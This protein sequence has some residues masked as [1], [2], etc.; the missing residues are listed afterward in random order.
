ML[1]AH[2]ML[3]VLVLTTVP[4]LVALP[5]SSTL[6][7]NV[8]HVQAADLENRLDGVHLTIVTTEDPPFI[9]VRGPAAGSSIL[10][11]QSWSGWVPEVIR[12]CSV[13][14]GF[15]YTLQLSSANATTAYGASDKEVI[16]GRSRS[17][18]NSYALQDQGGYGHTGPD[19]KRSIPD[20]HWAGA[21]ITH[22]RLDSLH[23]TAPYATA[24][25]SLLV[26]AHDKQWFH[27]MA[28][29]VQPFSTSLW[30]V[31]FC[32]IFVAA[33]VFIYLEGEEASGMFRGKASK[34]KRHY[35]KAVEAS[36]YKSLVSFGG[37]DAW[38]PQTVLGKLFIMV[39]SF[40][41]LV[42]VVAYT[43]NLA[44]VLVAEQR[45]ITP[46]AMG[47]FLS[48]TSTHRVCVLADSA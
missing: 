15:T 19:G 12:E 23:M 42:I 44:A 30:V 41:V 16:F 4:S 17:P 24:P 45:I 43:A 9:T 6:Y 47:E 38:E 37:L 35:R 33:F 29:V 27:K 25:L 18:E 21:Y 26:M 10:P 5:S 22:K 48:P 13:K 7:G 34:S 11:W 14:S 40:W 46:S 2:L 8:S 20:V 3:V 31:F 39:W 1:A 28:S 36:L 32:S